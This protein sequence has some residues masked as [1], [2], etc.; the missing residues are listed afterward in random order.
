MLLDEPTSLEDLTKNKKTVD[1]NIGKHM[2]KD[3]TKPKMNMLNKEK[4]ND[5][6]QA[7]G[8]YELPHGQA[9]VE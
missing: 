8:L 2:H 7:D 6:P 9:E 5:R 4:R 1:N 3:G